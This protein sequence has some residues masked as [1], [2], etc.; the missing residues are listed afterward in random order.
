MRTLSSNIPLFIV[1]YTDIPISVVE[2]NKEHKTHALT[3]K[4]FRKRG[5]SWITN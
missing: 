3:F 2:L 4:V 1:Q 5:N